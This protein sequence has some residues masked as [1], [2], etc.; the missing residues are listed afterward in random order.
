MVEPCWHLRDVL[1]PGADPSRP[2]LMVEDLIIPAGITAI[3]GPSGS[4]KSSL[5]MLLAGAVMAARGTIVARTADAGRLPFFWS[6]DGGWWP[7]LTVRGHLAAVVPESGAKN[8][9][10]LLADFDLATRA[11][12][13]PERLSAG[14]C[15]R[16][17]VARG[18]AGGARTLLLDEP[19]AHLDDAH[20]ARLWERLLARAAAADMDLV[21]ATHAPERVLGWAE[22]AVCLHDGRVLA[23]ARV[24]D[25]Y[26]RPASEAVASCLGVANWFD[27]EAARHW[28][29]DEATAGCVRPERLAV[30]EDGEAS[31][32]VAVSRFH[33]VFTATTI[34]AGSASRTLFHRSAGPLAVGARV[35]LRLLSLV[36]AVLLT[37]CND[38]SHQLPA[39]FTVVP[40]P[41]DGPVQPAPR[42][43]AKG[44]GGE[45]V[46]LDTAG[47][48]LVYGDGGRLLRQWRMPAW[49]AGRPENAC[50]LPDGRVVV[51]DTHYH[52]I[53]IFDKDGMVLSMFGSAG[54]GPGQFRWP[55]GV[56]ADGAGNLY[57]SEYG[58]NDRIQVFDAQGRFLRTFGSFGDGP[59]QLQRPQNLCWQGDGILVADAMNNRLQRFRAD[60]T[61]LG[62]VGGAT[63][64]ELR[65]PYAVAV[66]AAG[67]ITVVE[68][69]GNRVTRLDRD[70]R[71]LAR[72]GRPGR[73]A[74]EFATPWGMAMDAAGRVWVADT[75]NRRLVEVGP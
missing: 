14:E 46:V 49:E 5:L 56:C 29:G 17:A 42:G 33:G 4:G 20:A 75:G 50:V 30:V 34:T 65:F 58:G 62:V 3:I 15:D 38:A 43:V 16:L 8:I 28:L 18:L 52:R 70:G 68:Y 72:V 9:D 57:V 74:G 32:T 26:H 51:A 25:L 1:L 11:D 24:E 35:T 71:V 59:G 13:L 63:P 23:A 2:R 45:W 61:C 48:V 41:P 66:D 36:L 54:D 31:S 69:S 53:V 39:T 12:M 67:A 7:G 73:G 55:V 60:G 44:L 10:G 21:Y 40:L 64:P 22:Q 27:A 6:P 47:R 37:G 19:F